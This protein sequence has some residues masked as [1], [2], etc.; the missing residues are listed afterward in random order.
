MIGQ[1]CDQETDVFST[2]PDFHAWFPEVDGFPR[3]DW[4]IIREWI[5]LNVVPEKVDDAWRESARVWLER[6]CRCLGNSYRLAE[7]ENFQLLSGLD[8]KRADDLLQFLEQSRARILRVLGDLSLPGHH[9]KH[10]VMRF[11]T[12]GEYYRYIS[13]FDPEGEYAGSS[14][15]FLSG[16]YPH[17]ACLSHETPGIDRVTL[18]HE[19]THNLLHG[20]SLPR[21]LNEGLAMEFERDVSGHRWPPVT[22]E[23]AARHAEYWNAQTIQE[24]WEGAFFSKPEG[25]ELA[26]GLSR[27]LMDLIATDLRPS[28]SRFRDFLLHA[29]RR[30]AGAAAASE[31]LE[32]ELDELVSTFLGPGEWMPRSA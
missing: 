19:L 7:S 32:V 17:I 13:Y 30:D 10:V 1:V 23:L 12:E 11:T 16:G 6:T 28:P 26:Y 27:V 21:W 8:A 24:F 15:R 20:F 4:N 5:R 31:Y 14:G 2:T 22:R 18:V 3:P 25:Q 9:D 29:D